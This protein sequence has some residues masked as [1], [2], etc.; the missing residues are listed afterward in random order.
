MDQSTTTERAFVFLFI[1]LNLTAYLSNDAYLP[2]LPFVAESFKITAHTTQET[3]TMW[4]LGTLSCQF[5]FGPLSEWLGRRKVML[6]GCAIYMLAALICATS[7]SL[8]MLLAGRFFLGVALPAIAIPGFAAINELY[9]QQKA[10]KVIA[11]IKSIVIST[12]VLG[13]LLGSFVLLGLNWRYIFAFLALAELFLF[14]GLFFKM[15]ETLPLSNRRPFHPIP[16]IRDY[17]NLLKSKRFMQFALSQ[18]L[19][20]SALILW[21]IAGPFLVMTQNGY[22]PVVFGVFQACIFI[23]YII[24]ARITHAL[25]TS[26]NLKRYMNGGLL[27]AFMAALSQ[28]ILILIWPDTLAITVFLMA[29]VS[30]GSG[31]ALPIFNRLT[32]EADT[33]APMGHRVTLALSI[34]LTVI[35]LLS[36][37]YSTIHIQTQLTYAA[38]VFGCVGLATLIRFIRA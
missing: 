7:T 34:T 31:L 1:C 6:L 26:T 14:I 9:D 35:T 33:Q 2:A 24:G 25:V 38:T 12:A 28:L 17:L 21:L 23:S 22:S 16:I 4:F 8:S 32:I 36:A 10:I 37:L 15:S 18:G 30:F 3:M 20:N 29:V 19:L 11:H 13:A 5:F 27:V